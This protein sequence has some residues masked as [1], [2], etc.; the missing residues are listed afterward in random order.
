MAAGADEADVV[1][2]PGKAKVHEAKEAKA[3]E[4]DDV[5][6]TNKA[7]DATEANKAKA[8][9]AN[10]A[11]DA[12]M[13]A[14][15]DET[16]T[17][18]ADKAT[19]AS[20]ADDVDDSG[21][22]EVAKANEADKAEANVANKADAVNKPNKADKA[23]VADRANLANKANKADSTLL[24]NGIVIVLYPLTKYSAILAE[25]KAY[26]GIFVFNNQLVG[27]VWS[28]LRSLKCQ[29]LQR[30]DIEDGKLLS[31]SMRVQLCF[32]DL[33]QEVANIQ[34]GFDHVCRSNGWARQCS[35]GNA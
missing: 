5:I 32:E 18:K 35:K 17:N 6:M 13:P 33:K 22:A 8:T 34:V 12:V 7:V 29:R 25:V 30:A 9:E 31:S 14:E 10:E 26:F 23:H 2:E 21:D 20:L 19:E 3:N 1:D 11:D 4:A 16:E 27:M 28:C 24:D 15:V